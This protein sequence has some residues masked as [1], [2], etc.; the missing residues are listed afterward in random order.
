LVLD[1]NQEMCYTDK[2]NG[3][4]AKEWLPKLATSIARRDTF[5][6]HGMAS[7]IRPYPTSQGRITTSAKVAEV[8]CDG[9]ANSA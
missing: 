7:N 6:I 1:K 9:N 3:F 8:H 5:S 2:V 4:S